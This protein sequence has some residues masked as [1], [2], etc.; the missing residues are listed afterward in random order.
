[1]YVKSS[2][3]SINLKCIKTTWK[4]QISHLLMREGDAKQ[5]YSHQKLQLNGVFFKCRHSSEIRNLCLM[6]LPSETLQ[7]LPY[8]WNMKFQIVFFSFF[9]SSNFGN[10]K[11]YLDFHIPKIWQILK[12]FAR[13]F[14][15]A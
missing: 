9:I 15:P 1:M 8:F 10:E 4:F 5:N 6:K 13:Q 14:H 3:I 11:N 2:F 12:C 7:N